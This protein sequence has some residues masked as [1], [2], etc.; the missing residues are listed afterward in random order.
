MSSSSTPVLRHLDNISRNANVQLDGFKPDLYT[1]VS[2]NVHVNIVPIYLYERVGG[3]S[4]NALFNDIFGFLRCFRQYSPVTLIFKCSVVMVTVEKGDA[5][6]LWASA[7]WDI[8]RPNKSTVITPW[9]IV[10]RT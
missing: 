9:S 8:F 7:F 2:S 6:A 3:L 5:V 4:V 10:F 1:A